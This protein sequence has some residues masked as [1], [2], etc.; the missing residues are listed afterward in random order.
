M[1]RFLFFL[2]LVLFLPFHYSQGQNKI[3]QYEYWFD[4]NFNGRITHSS[5]PA[6]S[7]FLLSENVDANGLEK[8]LHTF[9]IRFRDDSSR[10]SSTI[11]QTFLH[12]PRGITGYEYWFDGDFVGRVQTNM[13]LSQELVIN[14]SIDASGLDKGIHTFNVRFTGPG[15]QFSSTTSQYFLHV[16][17]GIAGYEYWFDQAYAAKIAVNQ[18]AASE[19]Q[20]LSSVDASG[21]K[22]GIHTFNLRVLGNGSNTSSTITQYFLH[23][24]RGLEAYEYWF[25]QNVGAKVS[26][27]LGNQASLTVSQQINVDVLSPGVHQFHFRAKSTGGQ[28][29]SLHS[30][31]FL[32]L[33]NSVQGKVITGY[34]YR[35]NNLP[36]TNI[37]LAQPQQVQVLNLTDQ[38]NTLALDTGFHTLYIQVKDASSLWSTQ[39]QR[40]FRRMGRPKVFRYT[41]NQG[42]NNGDVK[43]TLHGDG[44]VS[45]SS[46]ILFQGADTI[47]PLDSTTVYFEGIRISSSFNLRGKPLSVYHIG[48]IIPNDT[49]F[50]IQNAFQIVPGILADLSPSISGP[51]VVRLGNTHLYNFT[52]TNVGNVNANFT[53]LWIAIPREFSE[54]LKFQPVKPNLGS[55]NDSIRDYYETDTLFGNPGRYRVY[56]FLAPLVGPKESIS[57]TF[58]MRP[59]LTSN[60]IKA[61]AGTPFFRSPMNPDVFDCVAG[62]GD[63]IW[64]AAQIFPAVS[65]MNC[66]YGTLSPGLKTAAKALATG[67]NPSQGEV[68]GMMG[69]TVWGMTQ[70][71]LD[72]LNLGKKVEKY[73]NTINNAIRYY[74]YGETIAKCEDAFF[75]KKVP[76]AKVVRTVF[77][78]DPNEKYGPVSADSLLNSV[79]KV[80]R[81]NYLIKFENVPTATAAAEAVVVVDTL[82]P[83][84]FDLASFKFEEFSI[85][86]TMYKLVG[87]GDR[88]SAEVDLRKN[89]INAYVRL[90]AEINRVNGIIRW[91]FRTLDPISLEITTDPELGFLPPNTVAPVG[92]G[93]VS[94]SVALHKNIRHGD[95]VANRALIYFDLNAPIS[96]RLYV[97]K[98]DTIPP[99]AG[100]Q[101]LPT[102][103]SSTSIPITWAGADVG[104]GIQSYYV[105]YKEGQGSWRPLVYDTKLNY[106]EFTGQVDSVYSFQVLGLDKANNLESMGASEASVLFTE[107]PLH[108]D[109]GGFSAR[110]IRNRTSI[111]EWNTLSEVNSSHFVLQRSS[112]GILF[113]N[114]AQISAKGVGSYGYED[115]DPLLGKNYYRLK[116]VD[117]DGKYIFSKVRVVDFSRPLEF[118]VFPNPASNQVTIK[119]D[120]KSQSMVEIQIISSLGHVVLSKSLENSDGSI[121]LNTSTFTSGLYR[122][123][124]RDEGEIKSKS[125]I[126]RQ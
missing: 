100:I 99:S 80:S 11:S 38:I 104:S 41:P 110:A 75:P 5:F 86:N 36:W 119:W 77:A 48:V 21:L 1:I 113:E 62:I 55:L 68:F 124:V 8:G 108:I 70:C 13:P 2:A 74:G 50:V 59:G 9:N 57:L 58:S 122:I 15:Q 93:S 69:W 6:V 96:T 28:W 7:D 67:E 61:W 83:A 102:Y 12:V 56:L 117:I 65:L 71:A 84:M 20:I 30:S 111:L 17:R 115:L 85:G 116:M 82:N 64:D 4:S 63:I 103:S 51:G 34:R 107:M 101:E 123:I 42:G 95:V 121:L 87:E 44:F 66:A 40:R 31:F 3:N 72:E 118:T 29:S 78:F 26:V 53:P 37:E 45:G 114:I 98:I 35:F 88:V 112:D 90:N 79:N 47:R 94:F 10:Y 46:F 73:Y 16:P 52:F 105:Y 54:E 76:A 92:E 120:S 126:I 60:Q 22:P 24:P 91:T 32:K 23:V 19:I 89:N 33:G 81:F 106:L 49:F 109:L 39:F 43:I 18:S 14:P 97:N 125:L 25:D 27:N